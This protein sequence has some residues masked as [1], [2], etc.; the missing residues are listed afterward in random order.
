MDL[1]SC[2]I[3]LPLHATPIT[4]E[5]QPEPLIVQQVVSVFPFKSEGQHPQSV[6]EANTDSLALRP[7]ASPSRNLQHTITR[8]LLRSTTGVN[9]QFP[10][11][12]FNRLDKPPM[13]ACD[14]TLRRLTSPVYF[15]SVGSIPG[16]PPQRIE[17]PFMS[18]EDSWCYLY[19]QLIAGEDNW[20][21]DRWLNAR[22]AS[23]G[24]HGRSHCAKMIP[25]ERI[26]VTPC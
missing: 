6:N 2:T 12:D 19:Y 18:Q 17:P 11:P 26:S 10:G 5:D 1:P 15:Y 23:Y 7:V 24:S 9:E 13:T 20:C 22:Q 16:A 21:I 8:E 4:P 3:Y 14:L 25:S